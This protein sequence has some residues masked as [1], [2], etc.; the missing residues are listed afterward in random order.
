MK[1]VVSE[2]IHFATDVFAGKTRKCSAQP[3]VLHSLEVAAIVSGMTNDANV[4]TAAILHDVVEDAGVTLEQL[5]EQFGT[6]V[7]DLVLSETE[8]KRRG[9]PADQT[10]RIRKEEAIQVLQHTNDIGVKMIFLGDKLSNMRSICNDLLRRGDVIW[11]SFHQHDPSE[12]HWYY[13]TIAE[14]LSELKQ[15]PA[16]QEYDQLVKQVFHE[17][18]E[19]TLTNENSDRKN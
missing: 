10:W 16:W 15:Y 7:A 19:R 13:R 12:H 18:E 3:T 17:N 6:R 11:Q 8:D 2:A 5:K 14:A 4:I 1:D 9:F